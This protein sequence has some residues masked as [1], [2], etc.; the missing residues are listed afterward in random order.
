V[1]ST[2]EAASKLL[3][4]ELQRWAMAIKRANVKP[5]D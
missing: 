4:S 3:G 5:E 2:P 1:L